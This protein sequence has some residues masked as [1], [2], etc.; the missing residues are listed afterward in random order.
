MRNFIDGHL[1]P[2]SLPD[3]KDA[4]LACRD[5]LRQQVLKILGIDDLVPPQW[6]LNIQHK[7]TIRR[8]GY[9]IEKITFESYPGM[10]VPA[11]LYVP[12]PRPLAHTAGEGN[13]HVAEERR[14]M[15]GLVSIAGHV[16][17]EGKAADFLQQ[18]NVVCLVLVH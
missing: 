3:G 7:G 5:T 18:R 10:A 1:Q 11:L 16:Y 9:R 17:G 2:L 14:R 4:W 8:E 13:R 15:P 6:G 12:H